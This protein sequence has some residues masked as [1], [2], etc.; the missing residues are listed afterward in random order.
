[1][2]LK[3]TRKK[4]CRLIETI[5]AH[6]RPDLAVVELRLIADAATEEMAL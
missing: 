2:Q 6:E 1:M 3:Q 5:A 4:V